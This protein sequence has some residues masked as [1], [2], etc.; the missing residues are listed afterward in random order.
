[1]HSSER[2]ALNVL[3]NTVLREMGLK[4]AGRECFVIK[5][6]CK[7]SATIGQFFDLYEKYTIEN[8]CRKYHRAMLLQSDLSAP[9][10]QGSAY[11]AESLLRHT[12]SVEA[13]GRHEFGDDI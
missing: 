6:T 5:C 9:I 7:I 8:L 13:G 1:M 11:N 4:A 3:R 12:G 2:P 10:V